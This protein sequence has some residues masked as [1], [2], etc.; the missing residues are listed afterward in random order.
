MIMRI[1]WI[2]PAIVLF[3]TACQTQAATAVPV[4]EVSTAMFEVPTATPDCQHAEGVT[5]DIKRRSDSKVTLQISGL[6]P[7]EVPYII[8]STSSGGA[9]RMIGSGYSVTGADASGK[10]THDQGGLLPLEGQTSATWDIRL[11]HSRGVECATITL[12]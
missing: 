9:S 5:M 3:C 12:P 1:R 7:G 2:V 6:Q 8:Y 4:V 11:I 10:F